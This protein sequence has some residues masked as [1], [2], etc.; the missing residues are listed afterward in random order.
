MKKIF[1]I[2]TLSLLFFANANAQDAK[3]SISGPQQSKADALELKNY[4]G[5]NDAIVSDLFTLF[6]MKREVL[7]NTAASI[8]SKQE[9][10]KM[11]GMKIQAT[12]DSKQM[13]LLLAKPELYKKVTGETGVNSG[14]IIEKKK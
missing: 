2:L 5:M 13:G 12:L 7:E 3:K 4:L 8:E 14:I 1:S 6:E 9:M 11:V 10:V